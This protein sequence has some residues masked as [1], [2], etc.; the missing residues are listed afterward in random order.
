M[1]NEYPKIIFKKE[2]YLDIFKGKKREE[3]LKIALETRKFEIELYWKRATYFW[4]FIAAT[5]AAYF[6]LLTSTNNDHFKGFTIV[7]ATIGFFFSL[8]WYY[9]NRGS[10]YWQE[11]W[12]KHVDFLGQE[13]FGPLFRYVISPKKNF[14]KMAEEFPFSVSRVNQLLSLIMTIFWFMAF[15]FSI[16]FSFEKMNFLFEISK[17]LT[18]CFTATI[19]LLFG[20]LFFFSRLFTI[21]AY[22]FLIRRDKNVN[23]IHKKAIQFLKFIKT[24]INWKTK[25]KK[26]SNRIFITKSTIKKEKNMETKITMGNDEFILYIRKKTSNCSFSNDQLGKM[27]WIWLRDRGASKTEEDRNSEWGKDADNINKDG[28]PKTATQ[29]EFDREMLPDVYNYLDEIANI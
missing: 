27:I 22:S 29:F 7:I 12:E 21:K 11:N 4:A 1:K 8:G 19:I 23:F 15:L 6:V 14:F 20:L 26:M 24:L 5:F 18:H 10:K 13:T 25:S 2:E 28:L 16:F 9:V 3:A 17:W